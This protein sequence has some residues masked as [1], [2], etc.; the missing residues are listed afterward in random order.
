MPEGRPYENSRSYLKNIF[1]LKFQSSL[2]ELRRDKL[3][4]ALVSN[5][6]NTVVWMFIPLCLR[7]GLKLEPALTLNQNLIFEMASNTSKWSGWS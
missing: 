6:Q 2:V 7:G 3:C 1:C 5:P 4:C